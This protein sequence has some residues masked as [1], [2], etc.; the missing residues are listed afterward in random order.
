MKRGYS[1]IV[2]RNMF[3]D[4]GNTVVQGVTLQVSVGKC[5]FRML[6]NILC[7]KDC[8]KSLWRESEPGNKQH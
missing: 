3:L 1:V 5:C 7:E 8:V 2:N 6:E 4:E